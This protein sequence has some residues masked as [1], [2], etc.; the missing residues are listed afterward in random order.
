MCHS[1][2]L[3]ND[4]SLHIV[5]SIMNRID[6]EDES[7]LKNLICVVKEIQVNEHSDQLSNG[8]NLSIDD[9]STIIY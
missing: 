9:S 4:Y 7:W 2:N 6:F 3:K 8:I 1:N 5:M